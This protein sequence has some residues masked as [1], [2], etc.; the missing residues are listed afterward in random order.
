MPDADDPLPEFYESVETLQ[1]RI[2]KLKA[3]NPNWHRRPTISRQVLTWQRKI[4]A[5]RG[6]VFS[7]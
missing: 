2:D 4:Q 3:D 6:E 7:D 1:A 5:L